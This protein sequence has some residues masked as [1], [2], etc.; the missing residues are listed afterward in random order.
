MIAAMMAAQRDGRDAEQ[1]I[2]TAVEFLLMEQWRTR[3]LQSDA[4]AR[5]ELPTE[6]RALRH[7][8]DPVLQQAAAETRKRKATLHRESVEFTEELVIVAASLLKRQ[9]R[10]GDAV[11]GR[12]EMEQLSREPEPPLVAR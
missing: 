1:A 8:I 10:E 6:R 7:A 2:R 5:L 3:A 12:D 4:I 9:R 11:G